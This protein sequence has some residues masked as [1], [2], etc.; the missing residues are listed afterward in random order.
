MKSKNSQENGQGNPQEEAASAPPA[1]TA[2]DDR[3]DVPP[4]DPDDATAASE[5]APAPPDDLDGGVPATPG[6]RKMFEG[7]WTCAGC[8]AEITQLPFQPRDTSN[9]K[10]L[11][12]FKQSKA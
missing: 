3:T 6:E 8:G 1:G 10:C 12:C 4:P 11:D 5:P 9:L 7:N 2:H